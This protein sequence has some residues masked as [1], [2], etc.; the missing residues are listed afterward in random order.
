LGDSYTY[1]AKGSLPGDEPPGDYTMTATAITGGE[2]I[3]NEGELVLDLLG[4]TIQPRNGRRFTPRQ[5]Q[6]LEF[7]VGR[8]WSTRFT[9]TKGGKLWGHTVLDFRITTRE[10]VTVPAGTFN[11][12]RV[13]VAGRH[14]RIGKPPVDIM[15]IYWADPDRVRRAIAR[16][17]EN[18]TVEQGHVKRM[19]ADRHELVSFRQG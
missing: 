16:D 12:F 15:T 8:R 17:R 1:R 4:N 18:R 19:F 13:E 14:Y 2:V 9:Q 11:C 7:A 3:F 6:P 10:M 5:D